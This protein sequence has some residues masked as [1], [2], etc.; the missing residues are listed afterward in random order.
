MKKLY[1]VSSNYFV[2][3]IEIENDVCVNAAPIVK[4][5]KRKKLN[6]IKMYCKQKGFKLIMIE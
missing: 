1:K 2:C 3:G 5:M 4:Y 6:W